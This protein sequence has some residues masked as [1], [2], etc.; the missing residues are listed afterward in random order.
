[1]VGSHSIRDGLSYDTK[2][3]EGKT[4]RDDG[5]PAVGTEMNWHKL[6]SPVREYK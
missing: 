1:M 5:A 3:I 2:V 4:V 6:F